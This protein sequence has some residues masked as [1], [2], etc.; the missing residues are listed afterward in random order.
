MARQRTPE[1]LPTHVFV[2][3]EPPAELLASA[4]R[5]E[6]VVCYGPRPTDT[7]RWG[8][9]LAGLLDHFVDSGKLAELEAK[10]AATVD[11][12]ITDN[13]VHEPMTA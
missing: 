13:G 5:G 6:C 4:A 7:A 10:G 12:A 3:D 1:R 9:A 11:A 2:G 8:R